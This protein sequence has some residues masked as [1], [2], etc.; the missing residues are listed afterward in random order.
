ML[1]RELERMAAQLRLLASS[2]EAEGG[3]ILQTP[4]RSATNQRDRAIAFAQVLYRMRRAREP[5]FSVDLFGEPAWD[6]LL[7]LTINLD[8]R[9]PATVTSVSEASGAPI[10]TALRWLKILENAGLVQRRADETDRRR[11][12]IVLTP[13]AEDAMI[14]YLSQMQIMFGQARLDSA[15][16][17]APETAA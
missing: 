4:G 13:H 11:Q 12:F 14:S 9:Y 6:M 16:A 8:A 10:A 7:D 1:R 2:S 5:S 15:S 17:P 3:L